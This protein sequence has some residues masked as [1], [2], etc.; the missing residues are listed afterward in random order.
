MRKRRGRRP[1][2]ARIAIA[3]AAVV[4]WLSGV[5]AYVAAIGAHDGAAP[6]DAIIVLGA[7]AYDARPSPV[8]EQRIAHAVALY[9][10]GLA[11]R[12]VFTGGYGGPARF[13]ESQV[14]QRYAVRHGVPPASILIETRSRSTRE[15]LAEAAALLRDRGLG[16]VIVVSD[17]PHMAR[18]LWL[19][20]REGL[21]AVGSPTTTSRFTSRRTRLAFLAREVAELHVEWWRFV[22]KR[23]PVSDAPAPSETPRD[24]A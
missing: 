4:L 22:R 13:S 8:F 16:R 2:A 18:A 5:T 20:R 24:P 23:L 10:R 9:R 14:G 15:N 11:S 6:A 17:P 3:F 21:D 12:I 1:G 7:A 19:A